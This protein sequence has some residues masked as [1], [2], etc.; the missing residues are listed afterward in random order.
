[1]IRACQEAVL[2]AD[3]ENQPDEPDLA[4]PVVAA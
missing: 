2:A 3:N 1:L 4:P